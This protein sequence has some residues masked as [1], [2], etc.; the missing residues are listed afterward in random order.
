MNSSKPWQAV[1]SS[2]LRYSRWWHRTRKPRCRCDQFANDK[3]KIISA[4]SEAVFKL[5]TGYRILFRKTKHGGVNNLQWRSIL[6]NDRSRKVLSGCFRFH[7]HKCQYWSSHHKQ[8]WW[9]ADHWAKAI[10]KLRCDPES[11]WLALSVIY[12]TWALEKDQKMAIMKIGISWKWVWFTVRH[13]QLAH[14]KS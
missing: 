6:Q 10:Q 13:H 2:R 5:P 8:T 7:R 9:C 14:L 12:A 11:K 1:L 3:P 4:D